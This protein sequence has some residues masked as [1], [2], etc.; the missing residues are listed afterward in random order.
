MFDTKPTGGPDVVGGIWFGSHTAVCWNRTGATCV[1][2]QVVQLALTPGEATE[3]ATNDANSYIPGGSNDTVFNTVID[4]RLSQVTN[5]IGSSVS[6]GGIFAVC[7]ETSIAD[8]AYGN[9][10]FFGVVSEAYVVTSSGAVPGDPLVV[11]ASNSNCFDAV[12]LAS[13]ATVAFFL[14]SS[15]TSTSKTLKKVFLHNGLFGRG[16]GAGAVG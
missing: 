8:N 5:G 3:I 6:R 1:K 10:Q 4:P 16:T 14:A 11:K 7:L 12:G 2:G 13:E 9:F 15:N